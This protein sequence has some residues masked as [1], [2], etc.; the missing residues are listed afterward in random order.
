MCKSPVDHQLL[1]EIARFLAHRHNGYVDFNDVVT[2]NP[3]P[4]LLTVEWTEDGH[5]YSTQIG[6][7]AACDWWLAQSCFHMVK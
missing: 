5:D 6:T 3:C 2:E 4:G 1:C 7:A